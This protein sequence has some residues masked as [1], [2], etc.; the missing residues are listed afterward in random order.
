MKITYEQGIENGYI[1]MIAIID[2]KP[3]ETFRIYCNIEDQAC[4][5]TSSKGIDTIANGVVFKSIERA[6]SYIKDNVKNNN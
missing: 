3:V 5:V 6:I 2:G 4:S 1:L